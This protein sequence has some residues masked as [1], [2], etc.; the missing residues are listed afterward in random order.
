MWMK[1]LSFLFRYVNVDDGWAVARDPKDHTLVPDPVKWP[2]GMKAVA[3]YVHARGLLLGIY[4][5][6]SNTT[7]AGKSNSVSA[8]GG[9]RAR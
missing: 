1:T 3:D 7:C 4:S 5:A 8:G 9:G 2:H 6:R